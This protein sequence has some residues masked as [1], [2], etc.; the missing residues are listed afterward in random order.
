VLTPC[1][2]S[3]VVEYPSL[4]AVRRKRG[5]EKG[6]NDQHGAQT[7][8][9]GSPCERLTGVLQ[10]SLLEDGHHHIDVLVCTKV[11]LESTRTGEAHG[12]QC[13]RSCLIRCSLL[14]LVHSLLLRSLSKQTLSALVTV[15]DLE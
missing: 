15:E 2:A 3:L 7:I 11:V 13:Q 10:L 14:A 4:L 8:S 6:F 1:F 9:S 5:R 12:V